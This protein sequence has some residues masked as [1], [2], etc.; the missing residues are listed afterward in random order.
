MKPE[1]KN[2]TEDL[3]LQSGSKIT[4]S[5]E[6]HDSISFKGTFQAMIWSV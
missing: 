3:K 5:T 6:K 4:R 1:E 2:I